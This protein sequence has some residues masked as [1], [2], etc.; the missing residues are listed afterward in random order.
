[1]LDR[2]VTIIASL[3][4]ERGDTTLRG[5]ESPL[6]GVPICCR[7]ITYAPEA[8][9]LV[10]GKEE[11]GARN[12]DLQKEVPAGGVP[13]EDPPMIKSVKEAIWGSSR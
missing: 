6:P 9:L 8:W 10:G 11:E 13:A 1:M 7:Q 5:V 2:V 3:E 12:V 4:R